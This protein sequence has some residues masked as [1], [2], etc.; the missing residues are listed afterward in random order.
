M[1][2]FDSYLHSLFDITKRGDAREESY[3]S[4][5]E[6]LVISLAGHFGKPKVQV[7]TLPKKTEAGNPDFRVWD[8]AL[9]QIG[10]I[11]AKTPQTNLG[12]I[13]ESEQLERYLD[14][15]PNLILTNFYEFR[16]YRKGQKLETVLLARP[17]IASKL[18]T[19][20][21]AERPDELIKLFE[22]FFEFS[23]PTTFTAESL[24]R[25][26][27]IRT[28]FLR[29]QVIKEELRESDGGNKK[30]LGFYEAFSKHL[31]AMRWRRIFCRSNCSQDLPNLPRTIYKTLG[32]ILS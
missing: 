11:E 16:L 5:L 8:G 24:A 3:Y 15:F 25:E 22:R 4:A 30:I 9:S 31:I 19:V 27:A 18:K 32:S 26:L 12:E 10:Y 29:D 20:P 28:R 14:T 17:M 21:P 7:T 1:N 13:E 6:D 23:I 2:L